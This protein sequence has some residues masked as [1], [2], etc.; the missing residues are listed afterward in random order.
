MNRLARD[1]QIHILSLLC[2]GLSVRATARLVGCSKDTVL[3]LLAAAGRQA[4]IWQDAQLRD[5]PCRRIQLD[6]V[7][8]YVYAKEGNV[9]RAKRPPPQAGDVWTWVAFCPDCK[10]VPSWRV[11][12]RRP[13]TATEFVADLEGRLARRIQLTT[14]GYRPYLEA[15]EAAFG[16]PRWTTRCWRRFMR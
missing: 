15:V 2:E 6:E 12:D 14:D 10:L 7:W 8:A 5:L 9:A 3:S 11:G 4:S 16:G 1:K 13:E